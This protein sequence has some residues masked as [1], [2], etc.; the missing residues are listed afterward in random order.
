MSKFTQIA[1]TSHRLSLAA[2]EEASR[3]G[4]RT[5]DIDHLLLAL[6]ITDQPAGQV[7]RSLGVTLQAAREAIEDQHAEQLASLGI[8]ASP[9]Q[10]GPIAFH[11]S[12]GYE[13]GDRA[14]A[15][16]QRA[17]GRRRRGDAGAVL[18]ELLAE[19][20]GLIGEVLQRVGTSTNEI[21]E[22]LDTAERIPEH[23]DTRSPRDPL[24]KQT[25]AFTPAPPHEVW[26]LLSDPG[27][28][29]EWDLSI[30]SVE[31]DTNLPRLP[32]TSWVAHSPTHHPDGKP[33]KVKPA[34]RRSEA[35][36]DACDPE[37]RIVWRVTS[38]DM[39]RTNAR[40]TDL[41][42]APAAGGTQVT[43]SFSWDRH[44]DRRRRRFLSWC[45][46]PLTRVVM[47]IQVAQIGSA[48]GRVFR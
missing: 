44:P 38:P 18:R 31:G 48:I 46:R 25:E 2:M 41:T 35:Q 20:T 34:L 27:R 33:L 11:E 19:P 10:S 13:W 39:D 15:I 29:P 43:I 28:L 32:G 12:G 9:P 22:H 45:M 5:A 17:G 1:E 6:T 26:A 16:I 47:G 7:L 14:L 4:H 40:V 23:T 42:L 24:S 30:G 21:L 3:T 36:I 8:T 37:V